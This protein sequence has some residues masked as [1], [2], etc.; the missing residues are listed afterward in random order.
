MQPTTTFNGTPTAYYLK[1]SFNNW[2]TTDPFRTTQ[3]SDIISVTKNLSAG[4]YTFKINI[5]SAWY[6]NNGTIQDTTK[7]TSN[8]GRVMSTG[9]GDCTLVASGGTYIFKSSYVHK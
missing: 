1:G 5:N 8:G 9:E 6:G 4:T 3:D 7:K 2:G